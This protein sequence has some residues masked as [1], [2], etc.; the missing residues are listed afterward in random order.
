MGGYNT[1][2]ELLSQRR[3]ALILP[4]TWRYGEHAERSRAGNEWEQL[5]RAETLE[6]LGYMNVLSEE[7]F[8]PESMRESIVTAL[9]RR[10]HVDPPRV[11]VSG[12]HAAVDQLVSLIERGAERVRV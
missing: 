6:R 2:A 12:A 1:V 5:L 10:D 11:D 8:R 4:R 9:E 3:W 7:S